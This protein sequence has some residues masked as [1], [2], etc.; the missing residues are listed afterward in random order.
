MEKVKSYLENLI[1]KQDTVVMS[2]SG[3]PDSM[4]LLVLLCE[5]RKITN[6][7]LICAHVN[8]N[9]R[10]KSKEEELYVRSFC[11]ENNIEF[12]LLSINEYKDNFHND[13]RVQRYN[14]V[15]K[16]MKEYKATYLLT[17]H[18]GDDLIETILM[19]ITRGSNLKGYI[20]FKKENNIKGY[21]V[22]R[23]LIYTVKSDIIKYCK[24]NG[25]KYYVDKTNKSSLYTRNRYRKYILPLLKKEYNDIHL[26]YLK[27]SEK[28]TEYDEFVKGYINN[29][30]LINGSKIDLNSFNLENDFIKRRVIETLINSVQEDNEFYV[31]DNI[32]NEI[33]KLIGSK[34][35]KAQINLPNNFIGYK[36]KKEFYIKK[37]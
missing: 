33:L 14:F 25:I 32:I 36:E 7:N 5:L 34:K 20:G 31:T 10:K 22:I 26:K 1:T 12:K 16:L 13:A 29:K 2:C 23:P 9:V 37:Q 11:E 28:L 18:H 30:K 15:D 6:F 21:K 17:A 4:C 19:R 24:N 35:G 8:H 3:G 27:F